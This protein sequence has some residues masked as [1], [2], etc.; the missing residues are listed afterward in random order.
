MKPYSENTHSSNPGVGPT[1][2]SFSQPSKDL[3]WEAIGDRVMG[4]ESDGSMV[5]SDEGYGVFTGTVRLDNGGGFASVKA[6]LPEPL[7]ASQY[8]G[9]ELLALG[10]GRTYKLGLR[11][12]TDRQ[13]PVY[14]HHFTPGTEHWGLVRLPFNGFVP[15]W[16]GRT[17]TNA[18]PLDTG[19]LWSLSLFVSERQAGPFRLLM[20]DWKLYA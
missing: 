16:R 5:L 3:S 15:S 12:S 14:Q 17:L 9:I 20:Q 11:N 2:V 4:G 7:D 8:Q 6:D 19:N 10:D 13:S 1:V 18:E